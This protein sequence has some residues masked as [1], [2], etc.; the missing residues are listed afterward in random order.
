MRAHIS[1]KSEPTS[2]IISQYNQPSQDGYFVGHRTMHARYTLIA[3]T[4]SYHW[5][6]EIV[7]T[8]VGEVY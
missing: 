2:T 8:L 3:K 1:H 6:K 7:T 5:F 4:K